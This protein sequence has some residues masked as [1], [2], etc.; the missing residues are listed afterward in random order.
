MLVHTL[1]DTDG[2]R[3]ALT[4]DT[5]NEWLRATWRGFVD[6]AEAMR[7]AQ[8]YLDHAPGFRCP[9]LLNDNRDLRGAWFDSVEWLEAV[10]L[11]RAL[12][13]GLRYVAH[14]VQADTRTD[15][16]TLTC[17]QHL[18]AQL[19]LQ[20]FDH[21]SHAESWLRSCQQDRQG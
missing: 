13:L 16:L 10:W 14:V 15:I 18:V 21:V 8:Q 2:S 17:P 19:E 11:P 6:P 9:Y 20:L 12:Q 5:D 4:Y 7:G 3:C 1:L